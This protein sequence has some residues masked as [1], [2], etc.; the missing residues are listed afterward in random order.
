M[1]FS[2]QGTGGVVMSSSG[3][4]PA[5]GSEARSPALQQILSSGLPGKPQDS[6][7]LPPVCRGSHVSPEIYDGGERRMN[8]RLSCC[9]PDESKSSVFVLGPRL[10]FMICLP[11]RQLL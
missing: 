6:L 4:S 11:A 9:S 2:E 1:G 5:Q 7:R 10:A 8:S 3:I